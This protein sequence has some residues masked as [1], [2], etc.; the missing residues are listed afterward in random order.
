MKRL[1]SIRTIRIIICRCSAPVGEAAACG[2]IG[3]YCI[4]IGCE[5]AGSHARYAKRNPGPRRETGFQI[6][7]KYG[8]IHATFLRNP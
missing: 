5:Y 1:R 6:V 3:E 7:E 2:V 4:L 8:C